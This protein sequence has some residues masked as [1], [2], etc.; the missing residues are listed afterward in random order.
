M[1]LFCQK[2]L[3][4]FLSDE[5]SFNFFDFIEDMLSEEN[6]NN[7]KFPIELFFLEVIYVSISVGFEVSA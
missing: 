3:N 6:F 4:Y 5:N 1:N 2:L 7:I